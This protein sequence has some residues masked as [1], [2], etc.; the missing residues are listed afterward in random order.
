M[1]TP[2]KLLK[3][4]ERNARKHMNKAGN[5]RHICAETVQAERLLRVAARV[6][7]KL[8][9]EDQARLL[10]YVKRDLARLN[11]GGTG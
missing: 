8:E 9:P 5:E 3:S 1:S 10:P 6:L 7:P 4:L 11:G 2:T